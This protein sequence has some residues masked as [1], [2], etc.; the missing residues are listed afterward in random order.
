MKDSTS[1][2]HITLL[3][4]FRRGAI[5]YCF[6]DGFTRALELN[7]NANSSHVSFLH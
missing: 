4:T 6:L 1:G 5:A 7:N 2:L 3:Y